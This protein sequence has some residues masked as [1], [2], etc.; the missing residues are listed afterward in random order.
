LII[1]IGT[2]LVRVDRM[3]QILEKHGQRFVQRILTD[4][5][6]QVLAGVCSPQAFLAKRFAVKEAASKALGTGIGQ[7]S[8][9]DFEISN[10]SAGTPQLRFSG[11]A[12]KLFLQKRGRQILVSIADEKDI[13]LAF[14]VLSS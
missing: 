7:V 10:S 8:W 14:V 3:E 11:N 2:D 6:R 12:Q 1:G 13:A 9:Q 5:E 4:A